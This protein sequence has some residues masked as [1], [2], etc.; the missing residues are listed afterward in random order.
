MLWGTSDT[1]SSLRAMTG[2]GERLEVGHTS[3][4]G[5][6]ENPGNDKVNCLSFLFPPFYK[7]LLS[8][9]PVPSIVLDTGDHPPL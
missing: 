6:K 4:V 2:L 7:L 5:F 3:K 8:V 1:P 9:Y